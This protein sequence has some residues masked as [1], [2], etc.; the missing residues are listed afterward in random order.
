MIASILAHNGYAVGLYTSPHLHTLRER[1]R[2]GGEPL[3]EGDF[4]SLVERAWPV[5]EAMSHEGGQ[6]RVTT[7]ELLT[8]MAF[9]HFAETRQE[10]EVLEV[11][12]G[13]TL[14]ATNVV[15]APLVC[16]LTSI[17]LDHTDVLGSRVEE[18]ARDKA[19]IIKAGATVVTA[20]Q[21]PEAMAVVEQ[22]CRERGAPL[23]KVED[24]YR[25]QAGPWDLDGQGFRVAGPSGRYDLWMPLLGAYQMENA[26]CAL[27]AVEALSQRGFRIT[28]ASIEAGFRKVQWPGRLEVLLRSPQLVVD[29]AH[30]PYSMGR[31]REA[32]RRH[33]SGRGCILVMG[34]T[35]GHDL[36]G[37]V[38]EAVA[39]QPSLVLATRSR[40]PRALPPGRVAEAFRRLGVAAQE[41]EP[42]SLAVEQALEQ[43]GPHEMILGTGSIFTVAEVRE[44]VLGI[45][46]EVY[47]ELQPGTLASRLV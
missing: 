14:D 21:P 23:V 3:S 27:A 43:V 31:L 29:A 33:F 30:N 40:H 47:P 41:V 4:A 32:V 28:T 1:I 38:A 5:V 18:I 44:R 34:T 39:L 20:P 11:G 37:M 16:V 42:V 25:W 13:G 12:L 8:A 46:A 2:V 10:F 36:E 45:P 7:F 35:E 9:W 6:G 24:A 17:S 26:C 15:E 22:V 19:G